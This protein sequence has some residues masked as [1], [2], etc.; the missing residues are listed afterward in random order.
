S[1]VFSG[2]L[3]REQNARLLCSARIGLNPQDVTRVPGNVFP[4]KIIEYLAAGLHVLS[5]FRGTLEPELEAGIT[6]IPDNDPPAIAAGLKEVIE[7]GRPNTAVQREAMGRYGPEA[8]ALSL[9]WL[10]DQTRKH[11]AQQ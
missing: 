9:D 7:S 1:I 4:F 3:N 5:T 2:L 6:Y 8:V 11:T 10:I